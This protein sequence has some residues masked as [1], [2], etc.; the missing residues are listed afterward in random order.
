MTKIRVRDAD[1][2]PCPFCGSAMMLRDALWPSEGDTDGIL[3]AAPTDCPL[4]EFSVSTAD[5]CAS[6][7]AA[8]NKRTPAQEWQDIST[9]PKDG[10]E[11]EVKGDSGPYGVSE[12]RGR[13]KW[14]LPV[15]WHRDNAHWVSPAGAMLSLAG[16]SPTH[17]R[18]IAVIAEERGTK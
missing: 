6:V 12:W 7:A 15:N 9:A 8:W 4:P 18:P 5:E 14:F 2:L 17:W 10:R 1:L 11:I 3:H 13:A 16:Y